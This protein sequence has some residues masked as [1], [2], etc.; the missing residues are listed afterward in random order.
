MRIFQ[1]ILVLFAILVNCA[2]VKA[3][4]NY[5]YQLVAKSDDPILSQGKSII[6]WA[7]I[8]N[9]GSQIWYSDKAN[10]EQ[11]QGSQCTDYHNPIHLGT[12]NQTDR[13]SSFWDI[14][15]WISP[16]RV[17]S[18]DQISAEPGQQMSFGFIIQVPIDQPNGLYKECFAP[19]VENV[20]WMNNH[21][22]CWNITVD[23]NPQVISNKYQAQK[24]TSDKIVNIAQNEIID[25]SFQAKNVGQ[26]T[27]FRDGVNPIH[28]GTINPQDKTSELFLDSWLTPNRPTGLKEE[29]VKPGDVGTFEF[30]IKTPNII[31]GSSIRY[32]DSYWLVAENDQWFGQDATTDV[33]NLNVRSVNKVYDERYSFIITD[34]D[35]VN[36]YNKEE[37]AT[38]E[39]GLR[40]GNNN[41][42]PNIDIM[43]TGES[44]GISISRW[45]KTDQ[46]GYAYY[47]TESSSSPVDGEMIF[48]FEVDHTNSNLTTK[49]KFQ[50]IMPDDVIDSTKSSIIANKQVFQISD[51]E[52]AKMQIT[53]V[54][55]KNQPLANKSFV[56]K[57]SEYS[58]NKNTGLINLDDV[59]LTTNSQGETSYIFHTTT[60]ASYFFSVNCDDANGPSTGLI[61]YESYPEYENTITGKYK[62]RNFNY[63][64]SDHS[65]YDTILNELKNLATNMETN[66]DIIGFRVIYQDVWN[67]KQ[68]NDWIEISFKEPIVIQTN[69]F[70]GMR[71]YVLDNKVNQVLLILHDNQ[72]EFLLNK[73]DQKVDDILMG[74]FED[75]GTINSDT[76]IPLI[77]KF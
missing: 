35:I 8:K 36:T 74:E 21:D 75:T 70:D 49:V 61:Y 6:L 7:T 18:A 52:Q 24:V 47:Q 73:S 9:V 20:T 69:E 25:I 63:N 43:L 64:Q 55:Q 4:N 14:D 62:G 71:S 2:S 26:V 28:F 12:I 53:L 42:V 29:Y 76:L 33:F 44:E 37:Y 34:K 15:N 57:T 65:G 59:N 51:S 13:L 39:I 27:W 31:S 19:V 30:K 45:L 32:L 5:G 11:C 46:D 67:Y 60:P 22:L 66:G 38:I 77:N 50:K 41:P 10:S 72:A 68:N 16:N 3:I 17:H 40:D 23:G 54:N 58:H 56:L 48:N 1:I